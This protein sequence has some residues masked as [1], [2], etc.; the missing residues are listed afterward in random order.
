MLLTPRDLRQLRLSPP[1][2]TSVTCGIKRVRLP[3]GGR[4][5]NHNAQVGGRGLPP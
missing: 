2:M 4:F 3:P 1:T 5:L